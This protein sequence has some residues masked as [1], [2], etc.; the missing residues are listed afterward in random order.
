[1][2]KI[3]MLGTSLGSVEIVETA[4]EMG[5]Y[6]IVTDNLDP[7]LSHAKK[8]ADEYWMIS[9][10]EL[11]LLEAKCIEEE[12]SA[13][14]AGISEYNLDRVKELTSRLGLPCYIE[15]AAWKYARD[16][17]AFKKKCREIGIPI[18]EEY[19]VSDPPQHEEL[20]VIE[21]PVVV[22]PV[23]GTGNKG[24]SICT[25]EAELI[26]GCKKARE[27]SVKGNILI[28]RYI[29][30]EETWHYYFLA[31]N[32]IR[33]VCCGRVFRQPGYPTFLYLLGTSAVADTKEFKDQVDEKC[34]RFLK[35]IGCKKGI[36]WFQFI[37]DENGTYYALEM[38]QRMSAD[39][40]GKAVKK[41]IGVNSI[42]W[43]LD[44]AL[45][46]EHTA[47]MLPRPSE[48]PYRSAQCVYYHFAERDGTIT[49]MHGYDNLDSEKYQV[50]FVTHVG[51]NIPKYRLMI[52]IVFN[53]STAKE[54]CESIQYINKHTR[55]LDQNKQNMYISFTDY[56]E[57]M[58]SLSGLFQ[59]E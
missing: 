11:D 53:A 37:K 27:N 6:T 1:M 35:E 47:D 29:T 17:S 30:G 19:T 52:R 58:N 15:D 18:V 9:T 39:C 56:D 16:K 36:S 7:E 51:D 55:I 40:S 25:N 22:K 5:C 13:V 49:A 24:L 21:Y 2:Q 59:Q 8:V 33:N 12:V 54:M 10:N 44:I 34:V 43:M 4:R 41:A 14:F 32:E 23:D 46:K 50:S 42:E 26:A 31:E 28:E 20:A 57:I 38:A 48:P 45:G 3:L